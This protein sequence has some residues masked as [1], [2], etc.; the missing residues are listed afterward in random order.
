MQIRLWVDITGMHYSG[1]AATVTCEEL[2]VRC[3]EPLKTSDDPF[4]GALAGDVSTAQARVVRKT[5]ADAAKILA[6]RLTKI[7]LEEM[8]KNDTHNGYTKG[9]R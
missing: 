3:F 8:Q 9:E 6:D 4:I 1:G 5:R 7:I 2:V